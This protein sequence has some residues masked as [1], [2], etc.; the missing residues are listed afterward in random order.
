MT[1]SQR[2]F[3]MSVAF[4]QDNLI[5]VLLIGVALL[6]AATWWLATWRNRDNADHKALTEC[7]KE[8]REKIERI[9]ERL[10]STTI[11]PGSPTTLTSLGKEIAQEIQIAQRI[12]QYAQNNLSAL[13]GATPYE[14]QKICLHHA[15]TFMENRLNEAGMDDKVDAMKMSAFQH[16]VSLQ[17]VQDVAGIALRDEVLKLLSIS[18]E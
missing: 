16:G 3:Q 7:M 10:P 15:R 4:L 6:L 8:I 11:Q 5:A 2:L 1:P 17:Q 12:P 13:R 18:P 14:V 9:F